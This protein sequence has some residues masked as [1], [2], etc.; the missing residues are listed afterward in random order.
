MKLS[1]LKL[2][3]KLSFKKKECGFTNLGVLGSRSLKGIEIPYHTKTLV[4]RRRNKIL[5]LKN[6]NGTWVD[7]ESK[8]RTLFSEFFLKQ[9]NRIWHM[10]RQG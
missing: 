4:R 10:T 8:I 7:D 9:Q 1:F 2:F 5:M 3:G 6:D